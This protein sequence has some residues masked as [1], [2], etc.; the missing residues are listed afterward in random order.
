[1]KL[2]ILALS[3][4]AIAG[5]TVVRPDSAAF[6]ATRPVTV[7]PRDVKVFAHTDSVPV[8]A[9]TVEEIWVKD[10]ASETPQTMLNRLRV[11]AGARGANAIVLAPNNRGD[12]TTRISYKPTLDNPFQ[13][14]AARAIWIG[15]GQ[16]PVVV[17][18]RGG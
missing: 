8:N 4:M 5:C 16:P 3:T 11:M 10:D 7:K 15:E 1:M 2:A 18:K 14:F 6:S 13:Y 17:L 12:N 9:V